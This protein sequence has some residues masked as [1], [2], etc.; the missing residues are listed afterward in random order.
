MPSRHDE[1]KTI[2]E[3]C[4]RLAAAAEEEHIRGLKLQS[5]ESRS[6]VIQ[7]I[8]SGGALVLGAALIAV[9]LFQRR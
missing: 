4:R 7:P 9:G 1:L 5:T 3:D 6:H 2:P 8:L